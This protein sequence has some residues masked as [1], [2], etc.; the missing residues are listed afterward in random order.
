MEGKTQ[1]AYT[2]YQ[3]LTF[4]TT[5]TCM[6]IITPITFLFAGSL[7]FVYCCPFPSSFFA[8]LLCSL[9]LI[10]MLVCVS[11][12]DTFPISRR[13]L[14]R[15]AFCFFCPAAAVFSLHNSPKSF[16]VFNA[17]YCLLVCVSRSLIVVL[18]S[19][20]RFARMDILLYCKFPTTI[21]YHKDNDD[22]YAIE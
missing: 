12:Y 18:P 16:H 6:I 19:R 22:D 7:F 11:A 4:L 17:P 9:L 2:P 8:H 20:L 3:A 13:L 5:V 21:L 14:F 1:D 10:Y 15:F